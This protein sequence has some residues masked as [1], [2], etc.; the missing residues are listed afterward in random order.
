[1]I[2]IALISLTIF[3][4]Y[5]IVTISIFGVP[6]SLSGTYYLFK[7]KGYLFTVMMIVVFGLLIVPWMYMSTHINTLGNYLSIL[8]FISCCCCMFVGIAP[9]I[10]S[11]KRIEKIHTISALVGAIAAILWIFIVCWKICY[12]IPICILIFGGIAHLT[13]TAKS[14]RDYWIEMC[15]IIPVFIC[16]IWGLLQ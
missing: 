14:S 15:V 13:K 7:D 10:Q 6:Y 12:V 8:P 2:W 4:V 9:N 11:S 1:M 5:N 3:L 16:V